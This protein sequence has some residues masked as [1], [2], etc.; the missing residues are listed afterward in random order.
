MSIHQ[1]YNVGLRYRFGASFLM[2]RNKEAHHMTK[3]RSIDTATAIAAAL[4]LLEHSAAERGGNLALSV[5]HEVA[6]LR[7]SRLAA[8]GLVAE[9]HQE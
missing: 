1:Q 6:I 4:R 3:D 9:A 7:L 5:E 2:L 8:E